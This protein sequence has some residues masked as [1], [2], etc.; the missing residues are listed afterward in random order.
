ME[1]RTIRHSSPEPESG[2]CS[3]RVSLFIRT[4][5][6]VREKHR[7]AHTRR[8]LRYVKPW[9]P[10]EMLDRRFAH[11]HWANNCCIRSTITMQPNVQFVYR[12]NPDDFLQWLRAAQE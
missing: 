8:S 5:S 6:S 4:L 3:A 11:S 2:A 1:S 9:R 7:S 10:I 12:R